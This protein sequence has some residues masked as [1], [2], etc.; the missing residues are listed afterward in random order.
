MNKTLTKK[1]RTRLLALAARLDGTM[2]GLE[3]EVQAPTSGQANGGLSNAPIHLADVGSDVTS[4]ELG[5]T[6]LENE[7][8]IRHEVA[9]ALERLDQGTYGQC[10]NCG[11]TISQA[12]LDALPYA[13]FCTSC[14]EKNQSGRL[15]N[16][17]EGRREGWLGTPGHESPDGDV[18]PTSGNIR[19]QAD[20]IYAAGTPG[21]G[22]AIGGLAGTNEGRGEPDTGELERAMGSSDFDTETDQNDA[23]EEATEAYSGPSGGAVGGTPANKRARGGT[24]SRSRKGL[25]P[26]DDKKKK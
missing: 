6:L 25:A 20:D 22:T 23:T 4:Q 14:A 19:S 2:A 17:N 15:V 10:E 11:K 3:G 18:L 26:P 7:A 24:H 21:G 8:Y 5:A 16:I 13:R 9:A 12:R 1:Y